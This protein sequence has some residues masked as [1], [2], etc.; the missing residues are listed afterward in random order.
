MEHRN[1]PSIFKA[2]ALKYGSR[3]AL[4]HRAKNGTWEGTTWHDAAELINKTSKSLLSIGVNI[5]DRVAIFSRNMPEW[6]I[7]DYAIQSVQAVSVP[8]Y[9]TT[10]VQQALYIIEETESAVLF[11]GDSEQYEKACEL[12]KKSKYLKKIIVFNESVPLRND[13]NSI[14]F[15]E[16]LL[17]GNNIDHSELDSRIN[18][19]NENDLLTIIYTSG[20]SGEPK[21]VMLHQYNLLACIPQ[22]INRLDISDA[23][24]SL[25][26][27]PLSHIFERGWTYIALS[28]G[29]DVYY[30]N[31]PNDVVQALGEVRPTIMCSVP[32]FFEKTYNA[33]LDKIEKSSSFKKILFKWAM[34]I[35]KRHE[36]VM[37]EA[38]PLPLLL[39]FKYLI[40]DNLVLKKG[41]MVFG[42][43]IRFMP[44]AGA[45]L[46]NEILLFFLAAGLNIKYG[47]GLTE[48]TATISCFT[49]S[50][51]KIGSVGKV[52]PGLQIKIGENDEILVKG[53]TITSGYY[54]NH[55]ATKAAFIDGWFR[56]G[57]AGKID[58][59]GNIY[60]TDRI[61]DIFKT[62]SGKFIA[63][64][65]IE[66]LLCNSPY[67][68]QAAVMGDERKF[69]TALIV[70]NFNYLA[71]Y[72]RKH[73]IHFQNNQ[74]IIANKHINELYQ[75]II[76]EIQKN[77]S[78]FE[79]VKKFKLLPTEFSVNGGEL[80]LTLK[81]KRKVILEKYRNEI[82][83]MYVN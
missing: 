71:E 39:G 46:S 12:F 52:L 47:Y 38:K 22:H 59:G 73:N 75:F 56:T 37:R 79:Q 43:R 21:G 65:K 8:V 16:F 54:K 83:E 32:R 74:D 34:N 24:I 20:T 9:S 49:N 19:L 67:I 77:L 76:G 81:L 1:L 51:Y 29:M 27:L 62:S 53:K 7:V 18:G 31:N 33:V 64:Q 15:K 68:D 82:E 50:N 35:G 57:D 23:D 45:S 11:A 41:K 10:S 70:P 3:K 60:L 30:L 72:A 13:T 26:F 44:C 66:N 40:A 6:T 2:N 25:C 69:I 63:P 36:V 42:G 4:Y 48:S 17:L 28:T 58:E 61:K 80:T 55:Q 14:Y 78:P 5:G